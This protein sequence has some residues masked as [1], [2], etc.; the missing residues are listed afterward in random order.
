MTI[1]GSTYEDIE[2]EDEPPRRTLHYQGSHSSEYLE[3]VSH[4]GSFDRHSLLSEMNFSEDGTPMLSPRLPRSFHTNST[5]L[6]GEQYVLL[7]A[8]K[9]I[10]ADKTQSPVNIRDGYFHM[11]S[12]NL[13]TLH[14]LADQIYSKLLAP[15]DTKSLT[16]KLRFSDFVKAETKPAMTQGS[17]AFYKVKGYNA[18]KFD[19]KE[20]M[21]MVGIC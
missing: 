6:T 20:F 15:I 16:T 7:Y 9:E 1:G 4:Q 5:H 21:V 19:L 2:Y 8:N 18:K 3:P 12:V 10:L 11:A 17:I 13:E 14:R